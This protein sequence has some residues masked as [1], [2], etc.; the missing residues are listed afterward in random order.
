M[1]LAVTPLSDPARVKTNGVC[2]PPELM[3]PYC[4]NGAE[5]SARSTSTLTVSLPCWVS[6]IVP[7]LEGCTPTLVVKV[8]VGPARAGAAAT[9]RPHVATIA[10]RERDI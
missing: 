10:I 2:G 3:N 1:K 6:V 5:V 7:T 4:G 8:Y 9:N